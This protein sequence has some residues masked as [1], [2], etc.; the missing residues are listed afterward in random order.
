MGFM[1]YLH[2][3]VVHG[4]DKQPVSFV[5]AEWFDED[6]LAHSGP[7][8][9]VFSA[10]A[11]L[12]FGSDKKWQDIDLFVLNAIII[13]IQELGLDVGEEG[14][15]DGE[16]WALTHLLKKIQCIGG[17]DTPE[18]LAEAYLQ[19]MSKNDDRLATY[20]QRSNVH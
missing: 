20:L 12:N 13:A 3:L 11:H 10:T 15:N 6:I 2:F 17:E 1:Q 5:C 7:T 18:Y 8:L 16:A 19:A 9:G 4:P 14:L